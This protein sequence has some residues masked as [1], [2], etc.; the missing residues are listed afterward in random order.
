MREV[1]EN[2]ASGGDV[3]KAVE[4]TDPDNDVLEYEI[5]GGADMD[6]F[7]N[8]GAQIQ[9]GSATLDYEEGQRTFEVELTATDPF[10]MS[11][12]TMVTITVTDD[13]EG[14]TKIGY[15][16]PADTG[17]GG[18]VEP[19]HRCVENGAVSAD[20]GANLANDC[21]ILLEGMEALIGDGDATLNWADDLEIGMWNGVSSRGGTTRV[22]S[23]W[24]RGGHSNLGGGML[25]GVVPESFNGLT[26]L[27]KLQ[28]PDNDI[29]GGIPDLSDLDVLTHLVLNGNAL[30]GS[31]PATLGQMAELD[32]LYL[33]GN[34]LSGEIPGALGDA[35][36]LRRL[37]LHNNDLTGS[38]PTSLGNLS[39]LRYL[40]LSNNMLDGEIP[41]ELGDATNIKLLYLDGNMLTGM[42]PASLGS[43]MTDADDTLRRLYLSNNMLTGD[44]PSELGNLTDLA[45]LR[46][47]GNSLTGC[48]PA[49]DLR[50]R[51][52]RRRRRPRSLPI[53]G[54][55]KTS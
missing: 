32:Y 31:V 10:G 13:D 16:A 24:L 7:T 6:K 17:E 19:T 35:S 11:G 25:S 55:R 36:R 37:H 27:E 18:M 54:N 45:A 47:S 28:L 12:S 53:T 33:H 43:I 5:T 8:D 49:A 21:L 2:T 34:D 40:I 20:A 9:V 50:R 30:T 1:E 14:P 15:E 42:I 38:I 22:Y 39:R 4:A 44:V 46:L 51:R 41:S 52:R 23:I 29:G 48:I 3:G 26:A